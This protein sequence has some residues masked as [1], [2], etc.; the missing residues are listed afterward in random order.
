MAFMEQTWKAANTCNN[1]ANY[2][3]EEARITGDKQY[4][5]GTSAILRGHHHV[6]WVDAI[7]KTYKKK[8]YPPGVPKDTKKD[9]SSLELS[10]ILVRERLKL[11]EKSGENKTR[12]CMIPRE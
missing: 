3:C 5:L 9:K 6:G 12:N 7:I 1:P 11:F 10:T 4:R 2:Q 8:T